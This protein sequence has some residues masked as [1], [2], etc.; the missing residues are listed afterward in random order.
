[1]KL[2]IPDEPDDV[3]IVDYHEEKTV[4][5]EEGIAEEDIIEEEV[6]FEESGEDL[7]EVPRP[8][9]KLNK[10]DWQVLDSWMK[11]YVQDLFEEQKQEFSITDDPSPR[12]EEPVEEFPLSEVEI[13]PAT[14]SEVNPSDV[15]VKQFG[16]VSKELLSKAT[17]RKI[18]YSKAS[19]GYLFTSENDYR[20]TILVDRHDTDPSIVINWVSGAI[21]SIGLDLEQLIHEDGF[22][23]AC[24]RRDGARVVFSIASSGSMV[25]APLVVVGVERKTVAAIADRIRSSL[26]NP[27]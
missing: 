18:L 26:H 12:I 20:E 8:P 13:V 17:T 1:V 22:T 10:D 21:S 24:F 2:L 9:L 14:K 27:E 3:E 7:P 19:H 15:L 16:P 23:F 5:S 25:S 11:E 6:D 4:E